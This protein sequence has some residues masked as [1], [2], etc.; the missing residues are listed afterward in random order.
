MLR[1]HSTKVH[2]CCYIPWT[3]SSV[4]IHG[5]QL[6]TYYWTYTMLGSFRTCKWALPLQQVVGIGKHTLMWDG[7]SNWAWV[8]G[9]LAELHPKYVVVGI[10]QCSCQG[11]IIHSYECS[12]SYGSSEVLWFPSHYADIVHINMMACDVGMFIN[13][14][15]S[16]ST[17]DVQRF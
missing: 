4:P 2:V 16:I 3:P 9:S 15:R 12:I 17:R 1:S 5:Y 10:Y 6:D 14:G 8:L 11:W 7:C 13:M